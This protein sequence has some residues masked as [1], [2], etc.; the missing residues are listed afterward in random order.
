[1]LPVKEGEKERRKEEI[2]SCFYEIELAFVVFG[3]CV[4]MPAGL[5]EAT[6]V[7]SCTVTHA[8]VSLSQTV[9]TCREATWVQSDSLGKKTLE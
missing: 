2:H 9:Q 1:M 5:G 4:F 6:F 8:S 3:I 7:V